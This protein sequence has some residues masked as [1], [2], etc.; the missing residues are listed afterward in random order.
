[1]LISYSH[2]FIFVHVYKVAGTSVRHSLSPYARDPERYLPSRLFKRLSGHRV[3][4]QRG[5]V[6]LTT[7]SSA[8]KIKQ[9][10]PLDVF[11][12]FYKFAFVR[13][14]WDWQVSLYH[15]MLKERSHHQHDLMKLQQSFDQYI[16]WRVNE[17]RR[18]QKDFVVNEN[19]ELIVDF[20]G[21]YETLEQDFAAVCD[22]VGLKYH[23]PH[24][25][26]SSH[27]D[28]KALY[29]PKTSALVAEAFR[30]DIEFFGYT[31]DGLKRGDG[32]L[33]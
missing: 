17:D 25:N 13:N 26:T 24:L 23:L 6:A 4:P 12:Q 30:E 33:C 19:G 10:L 20:I 7:H 27:R 2:Q 14:P 11:E 29:T 8:R 18:L 31:F 5:L 16:E 9:A 21:R 1:M 22:Q 32:T 28:Y 3:L 15:F